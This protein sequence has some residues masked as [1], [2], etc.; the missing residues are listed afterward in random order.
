[1]SSIRQVLWRACKSLRPPDPADLFAELYDALPTEP[2]RTGE[3]TRLTT[4]GA[5]L[6]SRVAA[7]IAREGVVDKTTVSSALYDS[8][9]QEFPAK[10]LLGNAVCLMLGIEEAFDLINPYLSGLI[11]PEELRVFLSRRLMTGSYG[12]T[13]LDGGLIPRLQNPA[14]E[15]SPTRPEHFFPSL[16]RVS[17]DDWDAVERVL[18]ASHHDHWRHWP[19]LHSGLTMSAMPF[20]DDLHGLGF[21]LIRNDP[22]EPWYSIT[23]T[24]GLKARIEDFIGEFDKSGAQI[25]LV[26]ESTLDD[27][28]LAEWSSSLRRISAP[29]GRPG[30]WILV[31]SGPVQTVGSPTSASG[32]A[33]L[34]SA[35]NRAV[36][37][38]RDSGEPIFWQDKLERFMIPRATVDD[39][40]LPLA[41]DAD[42]QRT[43]EF[44]VTGDRRRLLDASS[45]R[46]AIL[47]CEDLAKVI[48]QAPSICANA[49][50]LILVPILSKPITR[51]RWEQQRSGPLVEHGITV[52]VS[53]SLVVARRQGRTRAGTFL[54]SAPKG[55]KVSSAQKATTLCIVEVQAGKPR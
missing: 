37:L 48:E 13:A 18:P 25:G 20:A 46:L 5:L 7:E 31:G 35:P 19:R 8:S 21:R 23:P 38:D 45:T 15:P 52:A 39:W 43:D 16:R 26:P 41:L 14:G 22:H 30:A 55:T 53:N 12:S 2:F 32:A 36:L 24:A 49:V 42:D 17:G 9:D 3:I 29:A 44:I 10:R 40:V 54:V 27:E 34:P 11:P 51:F 50:N 47:V 33:D 4:D 6:R 28:I 1:M